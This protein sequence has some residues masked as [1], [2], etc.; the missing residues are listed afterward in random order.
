MPVN[1]FENYPMS[2]KPKL[3]YG[4]NPLYIELSNM[5]E[6]D[7]KS[8]KLLPGTKL[9]PQRELADFLDINLSTISRVFKICKQKGLISAT[10]GSG[11]FVSSDVGLNG[12]FL[13]N[14]SESRIIEMGPILPSVN[15]NKIVINLMK[16]ILSEPNS[17]RLFQYAEPEGTLAHRKAAVKWIEKCKLTVK[18]EDIIIAAGGQNAIIASLASAFHFGD[19]IGTNSHIYPGVKNAAQILGIQLI[20]IKEKDNEITEEGLKYAI[21]NENIKGV[22]ITPDYSNPTTNVMSIETR[23]LIAKFAKENNLIIIEDAINSLLCEDVL[24]PIK[25][26][27]PDN[28]I[29]ILSISKV[30]SPGLRISFVTPPDKIRAEI[31]KTFYAMNISVSPMLSEVAARLIHLG[32]GEKIASERKKLNIVRNDI[33]DKYLGD[34]KILGERTCPFRWLYLNDEKSGEVFEQEAKKCGVQVYTAERFVV[35]KAKTQNAVRM[36]IT[37]ANSDKEFEE[38]IKILQKIL[39]KNIDT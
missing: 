35:G 26:F 15:E 30:I 4:K 18:A 24:E 7:I 5:L 36:A 8:G 19:R 9:P 14:S 12:M 20:P 28:T 27:A 38:G 25:Y 32:Y 13:K 37:S 3:N 16:K 39:Y 2:W 11:T 1:S 22:Y 34:F 29:H 21:N 17:E 10:I 23:K 6:Q 31:L 33:V